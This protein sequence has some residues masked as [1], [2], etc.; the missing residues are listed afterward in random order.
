MAIKVKAIERKLKFEKGE[1]AP[2]EYRYVM[3]ADLYNKLSQTKV[4]QEASLRSGIPKG[5]INAAWDAIGEVIKA[6]ATEGHAVAVP[7]LGS[8]RFGLRSTSVADVNK[9]GTGLI[10]SRRVIFTP[11][12]DIKNELK[13][14]SISITCIDRDGNI[15]KR[16]TSTDDAEVEDNEDN[17]DPNGG[18]SGSGNQNQTPSNQ[19]R[20]YA[21]NISSANSAQGSVNSSVNKSYTEGSTVSIVATPASG[22]A[23]DKWSDGNTQA[24]RT[25]TM[26]ADKTL[27]ASFKE[28]TQSGG[29]GDDEGGVGEY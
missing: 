17:N 13:A 7:G 16:V 29:S 15:V 24:S 27:V 2:F 12:V 19:S 21:L 26:D 22:F 9:V 25:V 3:Q 1:D 6:W 11:S 28:Q 20:Q 18:G 4:I 8:M 14:T 5:S 10:T 23:F